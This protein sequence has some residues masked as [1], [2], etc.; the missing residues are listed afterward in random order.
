MHSALDKFQDRVGRCPSQG[1][2]Y[3][4]GG[5]PLWSSAIMPEAARRP[6]PCA[7][8]AARQFELQLMPS[9]L[10]ALK[11]D[12]FAEPPAAAASAA[13]TAVRPAPAAPVAAEVPPAAPAPAPAPAPKMSSSVMAALS[14]PTLPPS[15]PAP[16]AMA[17]AAPGADDAVT[18]ADDF[19]T[20]AAGAN[21]EG[22]QRQRRKPP[23]SA[24]AAVEAEG[25][26]EDA[27]GRDGGGVQC[28]S[29]AAKGRGG[30]PAAALP[31]G[32]DWGVL[33]VYSCP[34]SCDQSQ[35]EYVVVQVPVE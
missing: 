29:S 13:T 4:W 30:L 8:G 3:A 6:P 28:G 20:R 23:P 18:A 7:C 14:K 17:S 33:A 31:Q 2:R 16:A 25:H 27:E 9:L 26:G 15:A 22:R 5:A 32:M 10:F 1:L 34:E 21:Y 35:E 19:L 12:D 11:V 24:A